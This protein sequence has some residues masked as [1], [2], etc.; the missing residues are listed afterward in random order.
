MKFSTAPLKPDTFP[1]NFTFLPLPLLLLLLLKGLSM[2]SMQAHHRV[3]PIPQHLVAG[4]HEPPSSTSPASGGMV[5]RGES[6]SAEKTKNEETLPPPVNAKQPSFDE[7]VFGGG[8]RETTRSMLRTFKS[9][10]PLYVPSNQSI[11]ILP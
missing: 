11:V 1:L 5:D 7:G 6:R 2:N 4:P 10:R 8:G 3:S 9:D